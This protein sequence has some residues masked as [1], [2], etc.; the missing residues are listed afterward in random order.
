MFFNIH[1][2]EDI[3]KHMRKQKKNHLCF[4]HVFS[5]SVSSSEKGVMI[6]RRLYSPNKPKL[7]KQ[8]VPL[9]IYKLET[10]SQW[11][12]PIPACYMEPTMQCFTNNLRAEA[13]DC[14]HAYRIMGE[15]S[16]Q[17]HIVHD[18]FWY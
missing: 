5:H 9:T 3:A 7:I 6:T 1:E 12:S 18:L 15:V 16:Y 17:C 8:T 10:T 13:Y 14:E 4:L 2:K 11:G